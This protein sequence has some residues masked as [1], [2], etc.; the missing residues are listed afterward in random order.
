MIFLSFA[1]DRFLFPGHRRMDNIDR[2]LQ[3]TIRMGLVV[4]FLTLPDL[5]D[6]VAMADDSETAANSPGPDFFNACSGGDKDLVARSIEEHPDWINGYTANGEACLHL[7]GIYGHSEVTELLLRK[8]ADPNIRSTYDKGLRMHPL[9]WNVYGGHLGNIE[10]LLEHGADV[11]LDFDSM[12]GDGIA[13]TSLDVL[14][15]LLQNERG[16]ERF[17]EIEKVFQKHGAKTMAQLQRENEEL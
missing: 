7:T 14:R 1:F 13:V 17:V 12:K 15:A 3:W 2:A 8:G 4:L 9:S 10:L 16:D 6:I 11:N 5:Y